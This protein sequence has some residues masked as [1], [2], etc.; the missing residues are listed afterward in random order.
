MA[1]NAFDL[2]ALKQESRLLNGCFE[3]VVAEGRSQAE[4][5]C[6]CNGG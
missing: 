2:F 3:T 4:V 6:Y 5:V 1:A